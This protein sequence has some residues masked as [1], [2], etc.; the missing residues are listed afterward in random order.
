MATAPIQPLAWELPYTE[1]VALKE[2]SVQVERGLW[3]Y[4]V[5]FE[6]SLRYDS[7]G[8]VK[9]IIVSEANSDIL[10]ATLIITISPRINR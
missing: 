6:A 9:S 8:T 7:K 1:G 4:R 3:N 2:M 5:G 10:V